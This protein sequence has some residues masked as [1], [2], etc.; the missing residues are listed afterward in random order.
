MQGKGCVADAETHAFTPPCM[1]SITAQR[2][3]IAHAS[4]FPITTSDTT[5][6]WGV[7]RGRRACDG[8]QKERRFQ[9]FFLVCQQARQWPAK[10]P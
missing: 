2:D 3:A 5:P 7:R 1:S 10:E 4:L 9:F 8:R 6:S